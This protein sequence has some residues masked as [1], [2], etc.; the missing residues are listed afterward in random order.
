MESL[1][2]A[3]ISI[4]TTGLNP[5]NDK[6]MEIA[7][8]KIDENNNKSLFHQIINPDKEISEKISTITGYSNEE[9]KKNLKIDQIKDKFNHFIGSVTLIGY[10]NEFIFSFLNKELDIEIQN[11]KID[12]LELAKKKFPE[13]NNSIDGLKNKLNIRLDTNFSSSI[14]EIL[15][16]PKI[17]GLINHF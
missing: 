12:M 6:I 9:L 2:K 1:N 11:K 17:Y 16:L 8:L 15:I 14:N 7:I 13:G 5:L 3:F 4:E 10:N